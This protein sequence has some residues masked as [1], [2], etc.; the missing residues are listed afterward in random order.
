MSVVER[1]HGLHALPMLASTAAAPRRGFRVHLRVQR[2]AVRIHGHQQRAEALDAEFPQA[3]GMQVVH[4]D[5]LDRLDPGGLQRG[6]AADHGEI[7]AAEFLERVER[8]RPHAAF[9]DDQLARRSCSISGRVKR[10]M[11]IDV[12]V[13]MQSGS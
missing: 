7:G 4:V 11:R 6:G 12:V 2:A 13:P 8:R 10:S 1:L 3:L 5:V 9:A